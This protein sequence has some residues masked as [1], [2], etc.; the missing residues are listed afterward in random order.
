M[1]LRYSIILIPLLLC[2]CKPVKKEEAV[3]GT[4]ELRYAKGFNV[5]QEG[6]VK[7]VEV[8]YPYPNAKQGYMYLLVPRGEEVPTHAAN[9]TVIRTP[10][11]RMVCTSTTHIPLLDYIDETDKLI[12]FPTTDYIS[13]QKMRKRIDEGKVVD[14]GV[15]SQMNMEVLF[16]LKPDFVMGYSMS[17]D[18]GQLKK[19]QELGI[20][21]ILNSEYLEENPL[22]RAEWIK[23]MALFFNK[24]KQADSIFSH[25]ETEYLRT[26]NLAKKVNQKP[27]V[28]SGIVYGGTWFLPGGKNYAGQLFADA[29]LDYLWS[30]NPSHD[31]L[32]LSFES[33]FAK[34]KNA[35]L[36]IGVGTFETLDELKAADAR[37]ANFKPFTNGFVYTY[38]GRKGIKGGSE[39]LEL[40]YLRPDLALKD[41][42]K[43]AHSELLPDYVLYFHRVLN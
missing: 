30:N 23:F 20:P 33:V 7:W 34:A 29:G 8:T 26:Q 40:G 11:N 6:V 43:I 18:L 41:L 36:W 28:M 27:T 9:I 31:W 4:L 38:N 2:T 12:G 37:Y 21:V 39:F 17:N 10:V 14:L 5:R 15:D 1:I 16:T 3:P 35:D 13:S 24:E 25:I 22:G 19:V 32:E 42:V